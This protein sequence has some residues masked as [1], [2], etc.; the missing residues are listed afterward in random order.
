MT[1]EQSIFIQSDPET[2]FAY[3]MD[4]NNR[5]AYI[6][7]LEE[8]ILIDELPIRKGSR[9]IEVA[10]LAGRKLRTTYQVIEYE[11]NRRTAAKTIESVFPIRA[12]LDLLPSNGGT[13]LTIRLDFQLKGVFRL[14][15]TFIKGVVNQ[16][17]R[18]IL[19]KIKNNLE[20]G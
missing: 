1:A 16:Q 2:I 4:V 19:E 10:N 5:T 15:S 9:Y 14:A 12:D 17:A 20:K 11:A 13:K 3:L 6:P 7:A 18:G 8:V